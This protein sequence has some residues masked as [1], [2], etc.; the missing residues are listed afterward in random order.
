MSARQVRHQAEAQAA[1][2]RGDQESAATH[3]NLAESARAAAEFYSA[4]G[5][6]DGQLDAARQDWAFRTAPIRLAAIQADS[7]LRRRHPQLT[8]E[9]LRSA[10]TE[11]LADEL[12][13]PTPATSEQHAALVAER[14][15]AFQA[16]LENR[17]GVLIPHEDPDYEPEGEAW[18]DLGRPHRDAVLQPPR[19]LMP[20]PR[21]LGRKPELQA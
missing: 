21:Q 1:L 9:P 20:Q 11:P 12:P 13:E 8:L 6:L 5:D 3:A 10:E 19:P 16:E 17:S 4:R 15:R 2:A 14:L 18:P 7:L